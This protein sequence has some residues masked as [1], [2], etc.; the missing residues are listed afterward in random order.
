MLP[1]VRQVLLDG[2]VVHPGAELRIEEL[3]PLFRNMEHQG[4]AQE[5][6]LQSE[7]SCHA[8]EVKEVPAEKKNHV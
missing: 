6:V 3:H 8:S 4:T 7:A 1:D 5:E 2:D